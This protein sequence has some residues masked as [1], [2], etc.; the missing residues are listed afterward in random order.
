MT[1]AGRRKTAVNQ[2][3]AT[4][5]ISAKKGSKFMFEVNKDD[6]RSMLDKISVID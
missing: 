4:V 2:Q 3:S 5:V 1:M 6:V